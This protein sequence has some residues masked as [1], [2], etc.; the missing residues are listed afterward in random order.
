MA[1]YHNRLR[2]YIVLF[3]SLMG[4]STL[5]QSSYSTDTAYV[6]AMLRKGE[7]IETQNVEKAIEYY[8]KG[9]ATAKAVA[10]TKGYFEAVRL[11]TFAYNGAGRHEEARQ[12]A[13]EALARAESDTAKRYRMIVHTALAI[14]ASN[15]G[16]TKE[17]IRQYEQAANYVRLL[18][19]RDNEAVI[20]N[21][22]GVICERQHLYEQALSFYKKSLA[23]VQKLPNST[24]DIA[25]TLFNIGTVYSDQEK[26]GPSIAYTLRAIGMLDPARDF[27][28]LIPMYNNLGITYRNINKFDSC[29]YYLNKA[30]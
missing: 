6:S 30:L 27:N 14:T 25:G 10:F 2:T 11:L 13:L 9:H 22:M 7:A 15:Q 8:Q 24:Y 5:A 16:D 3:I 29:F 4:T 26:V 23:I 19:R 21:N 18:G 1:H 20:Y 28:R 12:L 17:A